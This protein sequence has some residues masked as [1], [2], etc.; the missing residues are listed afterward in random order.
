MSDP[1]KSPS[2][3]PRHLC[4]I[5]IPV[6]DL[7]RA[8]RFYLDVFG[9]KESATE[10]HEMAL[11]DVPREC[12]FGVSLVRSEKVGSAHGPIVYFSIDDIDP[13]LA[14]LARSDGRLVSGAD[15]QP[16]YGKTWKV[17]DPDGNQWGIFQRRV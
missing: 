11:I 5:E 2:I 15:R 17:S 9:W 13:L 12:P 10:I 16:G 6:T 8:R 14:A 3:D 1:Q 4:Q 7:E